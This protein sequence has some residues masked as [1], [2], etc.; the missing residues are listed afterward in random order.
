MNN[1]STTASNASGFIFDMDGCLLNS[2]GAWH[3]AENKIL[4]FAGITLSKDERDELNAL[5][6]DE[7]AE[8]FH[9]RFGI[10]GSAKE[11]EEEIVAHL[12]AFYRTEARVNPGALELVQALYEVGAPMCVLSSSPQSFLQAGLGSTGLLEFFDADRI[13]SAEDMGLAKRNPSTFDF[14]CGKLGT[15]PADTWLFDDSWYALA[16]AQG[17]GLHTVG[18]FSSDGCGTHEELGRY[19]EKVIDTFEEISFDDLW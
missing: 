19:S 15:K 4:A 5:T 17:C 2:I 6:L 12:L 1:D 8:W 9:S 7:A 14:V 16:T 13:I 11:V 10:L 18:V 3:A